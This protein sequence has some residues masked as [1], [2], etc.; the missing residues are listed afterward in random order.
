M[1]ISANQVSVLLIKVSPGS[2]LL[3][4]SACKGKDNE[5]A[6]GRAH[7]SIL[8]T[9][10]HPSLFFQ[11]QCLNPKVF[12]LATVGAISR[13]PC[14]RRLSSLVPSIS[15]H[16]CLRF[17]GL[18]LGR[19]AREFYITPLAQYGQQYHFQDV[20]PVRFISVK[21]T[22]RHFRGN[23]SSPPCHWG[24]WETCQGIWI[25][26]HGVFVTCWVWV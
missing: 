11:H 18:I 17:G 1:W 10:A 16:T 23:L 4:V 5:P 13:L 20:R 26:R 15:A 9:P 3:T 14:D 25:L 21:R 6:R 7:S 19:R 2:T 22:Q 12:Q 24:R 8:H